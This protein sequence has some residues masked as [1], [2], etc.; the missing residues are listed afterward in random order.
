MAFLH[1]APEAEA[2]GSRR[3][4][5]LLLQHGEVYYEDFSVQYFPPDLSETEA[6]RRNIRGR[7]KVCSH[8]IF[9]DPQD[10]RYPLIKVMGLRIILEGAGRLGCRALP[11]FVVELP[12]LL[13]YPS[14]PPLAYPFPHFPISPAFPPHLFCYSSCSRMWSVWRP[15]HQH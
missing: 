7:L 13:P 15:I 5:L 10:L 6:L 9:F 12:S 1:T 14:A 11:T 8:S 2:D 3:F 4:S